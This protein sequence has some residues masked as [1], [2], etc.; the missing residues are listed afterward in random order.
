MTM[1]TEAKVTALSLHT[2]CP[3]NATHKGITLLN[4]EGQHRTVVLQNHM[5]LDTFIAAEARCVPSYT[6]CG[7]YI[8]DA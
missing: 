4:G 7:V 6:Q 5:A 1:V 3:F 2:A 8:L